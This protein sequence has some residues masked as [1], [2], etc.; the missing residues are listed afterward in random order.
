MITFGFFLRMFFS[1]FFMAFV[2]SFIA[3][4]FY[5]DDDL[6]SRLVYWSATIVFGISVVC[7][8]MSIFGV[9]WTF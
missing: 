6:I 2:T 7:A 4:N 9:I 5:F 8:V 1:S 3:E